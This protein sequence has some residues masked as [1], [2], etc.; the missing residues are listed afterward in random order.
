MI[1][2]V[3]SYPRVFSLLELHLTRH[4]KNEDSRS[5]SL[6][7]SFK[8]A[9][10]FPSFSLSLSLTKYDSLRVMS[11]LLFV[12]RPSLLSVTRAFIQRLSSR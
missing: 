8:R 12:G 9:V 3:L 1:K 5:L 4:Y 6:L 11:T 2:K 7:S 10:L